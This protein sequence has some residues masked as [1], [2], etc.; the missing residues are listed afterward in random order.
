MKDSLNES[1]LM[2]IYYAL[3][4]LHISL[5]ILSWG[6]GKDKGRAFILQKRIKRL[7][8]NINFSDTY[9]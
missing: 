7:I 4:Y 6:C 9:L 5:N 8:F 3:A 1:G 2:N